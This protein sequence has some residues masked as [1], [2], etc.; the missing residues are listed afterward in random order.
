MG[1][2]P[3]AVRKEVK[4]FRTKMKPN[5]INLHTAVS[6]TTSLFSYF[7][8][9]GKVCSHFY[10]REDGVIEQYID[11][12]YRAA[13]DLQGNPDTISIE[14]WD[15]YKRLWTKGEDLPEWTGRQV[16][17]LVNLLIWLAAEHDIPLTRLPHSRPGFRGVGFHRQGIDP[18]RVDGGLVFS[19]AYGKICPGDRRIAQID[20]IITMARNGSAFPVIE[21]AGARAYSMTYV[22][23][24]QQLLNHVNGAR[25]LVD[26]VLGPVTAAAVKAYQKSRELVVD[27][28]PGPITMGKLREE[29]RQREGAASRTNSRTAGRWHSDVFPL[30]VDGLWGSVTTKALQIRLS[31]PANGALTKV[32]IQTMQTRLGVRADGDFG[33]I[34][35][36]AL[37]RH[38]GQVQDGYIGPV[39]VKALQARLN[40]G[41]F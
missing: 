29:A 10:I 17:A 8:Q 30:L 36:K 6:N 34:T 25:L 14:T 23:E 13:A 1:W 2:Y 33:P 40:A 19:K 15:G 38:L 28:D 5:R 26:G 18:W 11:T 9:P 22:K 3:H 41:R 35:R 21:I 12:K 24:V 4:R 32:T 39:T 16:G 37:Q 27:G 31:V 7:N 20:S